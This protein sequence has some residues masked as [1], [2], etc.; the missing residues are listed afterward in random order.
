MFCKHTG[1]PHH[2]K[3][4]KNILGGFLHISFDGMVAELPVAKVATCFL[5]PSD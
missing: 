4:E 3:N 5:A 2:T 1:L